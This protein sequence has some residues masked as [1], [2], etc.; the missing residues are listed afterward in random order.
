MDVKRWKEKNSMFEYINI[1]LNIMFLLGI[2]V[3]TIMLLVE[4]GKY[5]ILYTPL[6]ITV[7]LFFLMLFLDEYQND[8][9]AENTMFFENDYILQCGAGPSIEYMVS[10]SKGWRFF[11]KTHFSNSDIIIDLFNCEE[12]KGDKNQQWN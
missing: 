8:K 6:V 7:I 3:F 11:D 5:K 4:A 1:P 2:T 12:L 10:R 9:I